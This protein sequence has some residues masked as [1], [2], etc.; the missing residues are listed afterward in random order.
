MAAVTQKNLWGNLPSEIEIETP[1][2]IL[3]QQG[4]VLEDAT[5][6]RLVGLVTTKTNSEGDLVHSFYIQ[7][8]LLDGYAHL[9][10][11]VV[12]GASTFPLKVHWNGKKFP[13]PSMAVFQRLLGTVLKKASTREVIQNLM[14]QS[15]A[16]A[17]RA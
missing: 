12:H 13:V 5:R 10:L 17:H 11:S 3:V 4:K 15:N 7:A 6:N 9:L 2:D 8:P 16:V 1:Y 14:A